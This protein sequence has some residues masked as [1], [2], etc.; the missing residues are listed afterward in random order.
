MKTRMDLSLFLMILARPVN[1]AE[2]PATM[3][4]KLAAIRKDL[5]GRF[6]IISSPAKCWFMAIR[7]GE[8][9]KNAIMTVPKPTDHLPKILCGIKLNDIN[10]LFRDFQKFI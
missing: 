7:I 1:K 8:T 9:R 5:T 6:T 10:L 4:S 3:T 2:R